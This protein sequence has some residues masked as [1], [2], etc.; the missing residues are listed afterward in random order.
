[1]RNFFRGVWWC[2]RVWA[3][4]RTWGLCHFNCTGL[5]VVFSRMGIAM[6][7]A[8]A[9]SAVAV[10]L[11]T[12]FL[13][14]MTNRQMHMQQTQKDIELITAAIIMA[15]KFRTDDVRVVTTTACLRY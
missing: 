8:M 3:F 11:I 10:T 14:L 9:V 12:V 15:V 13:L 2:G 7:V 4:R 6:L 1:M 5:F